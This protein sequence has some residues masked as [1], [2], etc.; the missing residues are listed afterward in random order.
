MLFH[1]LA[2]ACLNFRLGQ[3][4]T[5]APGS[6]LCRLSFKHRL[7][8][9]LSFYISLAWKRP[10]QPFFLSSVFSHML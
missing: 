8:L 10:T 9:A 2:A 4:P 3:R 6:L 1:E 7:S 5:S